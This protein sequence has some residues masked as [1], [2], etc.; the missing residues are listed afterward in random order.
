MTNLKNVDS[1]KTIFIEPM[2]IDDF[3]RITLKESFNDIVNY[4]NNDLKYPVLKIFVYTSVTS[5]APL[6]RC[7]IEENGEDFFYS[8]IFGDMMFSSNSPNVSLTRETVK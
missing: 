4:I 6:I 7:S 1:Y 5:F 2:E 3:G 8:V